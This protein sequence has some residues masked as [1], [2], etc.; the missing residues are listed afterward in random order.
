MY[1]LRNVVIK[2]SC[3]LSLL[4]SACFL[5]LLTVIALQK[6]GYFYMHA[7]EEMTF[8][9]QPKEFYL[10]LIFTIIVLILGIFILKRVNSLILFL[11]LNSIFVIIGVYLSLNADEVLRADP[12]YLFLAAIEMN[13]GNFS[14]FDQISSANY[15]STFPN[16][17]GLLTLFRLYVYFTT[18]PN[19]LF[20]LQVI[21]VSLTNFLLWQITKL[22]FENRVIENC[23]ILLSH[24]FLPSI[25]LT[26][27]LYGD[28]PGLLFSLLA[29]YF[30]LKFQQRP[31][32][33]LGVLLVG[34]MTFACLIRSNYLILAIAISIL[35]LLSFLQKPN[36][37]KLIVVLSLPL[38]F[39][40]SNKGLEDY[41]ESKINAQITYPPQKAWIVMGL[42][43]KINNPGYWDQY[44]TEIRVWNNYDDNQTKAAVDRDFNDRITA[45]TSNKE[46]A[47]NFFL[48]K[49]MV[50][51]H[52]PTFQSIFAGS[53]KARG[54][55][56][57]TPLLQNLYEEGSLY[58]FYNKY[59]NIL[60]AMIYSLTFLFTISLVF[61]VRDKFNV[62]VLLPL[63]YFVGGF[64]FHLFWETKAR[65]VY[66][67]IFMVLPLVA[68]NLYWLHL[69][70]F[71]WKN[72]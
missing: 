36:L 61:N 4:I 31:K 68:A 28:I 15:M 18:D 29:I 71:F 25:F 33:L 55:H 66:P 50:T 14:S 62:S 37:L 49:I 43:D 53:L 39:I 1:N 67:Y 5:G 54:Q 27:W 42:N 44:T 19:N 8:F 12:N 46:Y 35:L 20:L 48:K 63:I 16:Q 34:S 2:V 58:Q 38:T 3:F 64:I 21:M 22:L 11:I 41:Y 56:I 69:K 17:M 40:L 23:L 45:L 51:W 52:D 9:D 32:W 65:Y 47:R 72:K 24:L 57:K 26:L 70:L 7:W 10:A 6:R 30:Y 59:M 60:V 13:Q